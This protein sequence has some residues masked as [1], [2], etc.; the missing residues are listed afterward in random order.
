M[1][2]NVGYLM[3]VNIVVRAAWVSCCYPPGISTT[4]ASMNNNNMLYVELD[5]HKES[6]TVSYAINSEP[7]ELMGKISTSPTDIHNLYQRIRSKS[8]QV[9]IVYKAGPCGYGLYRRL[10]KSGFD[11]MVC[12]PSLIPK[13]PGER[14]KTDTVMPSDLCVHC[15][16]EIFLLSTYPASKMRHSGIWPG[17]GHLPAMIYGMQGN[18]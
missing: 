1:L 16:Q 15:V 3:R 18:V 8:S 13:K 7:V 4:E 2:S 5:V 14:G 17:H 11:C 12:A 10:V 6:I 9:S